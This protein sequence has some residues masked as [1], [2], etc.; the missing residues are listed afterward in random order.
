MNRAIATKASSNSIKSYFIL[1]KPFK[2]YNFTWYHWPYVGHGNYCSDSTI[3]KQTF[4]KTIKE[5][6]NKIFKLISYNSITN[7]GRVIGTTGKYE[8]IE[9]HDG[10]K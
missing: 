4:D 1:T 10:L 6:P 5:N 7:N 9:E 2:R 3:A 8:I